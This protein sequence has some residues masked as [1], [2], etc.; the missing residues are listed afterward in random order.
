MELPGNQIRGKTELLDLC[1]CRRAW[2]SPPYHT[3]RTVCVCVPACVCVC[4]CACVCVC[5]CVAE[6]TIPYH[7]C[8]H[9][10]KFLASVREDSSA[11]RRGVCFGGGAALIL[12]YS[13]PA[14]SFVSLRTG[15]QCSVANQRGGDGTRALMTVSAPASNSANCHCFR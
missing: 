1:R 15:V 12:R 3:M 11:G 13:R 9:H 14:S 8:A 2:R 7:A 5:V 6:P 10:Q 4:V